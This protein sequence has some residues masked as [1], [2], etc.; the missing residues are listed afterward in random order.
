MIFRW[1]WF[2]KNKYIGVNYLKRGTLTVFSF[3]S[4]VSE[5]ERRG[6]FEEC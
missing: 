4:R 2:T 1:G 3:K 5:K 6:G